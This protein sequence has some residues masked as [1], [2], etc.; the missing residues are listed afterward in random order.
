[1]IISTRYG[2]PV[3][4]GRT[5][6]G[7]VPSLK[8]ILGGCQ[9]SGIF[10]EFRF[11]A[12]IFRLRTVATIGMCDFG[13][14]I[15]PI[16]VYA[17]TC[18]PTRLIVRRPLGPTAVSECSS[19]RDRN[20]NFSGNRVRDYTIGLTKSFTMPGV[21]TTTSVSWEVLLTNTQRLRV[22][23]DGVLVRAL[24]W[25]LIRISRASPEWEL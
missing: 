12:R 7:T 20:R 25:T 18:G 22:T 6:L 2:N 14:P 21:K 15:L 9:V 5:F 19:R 8:A 11:P 10:A 16:P 23:P 17:D 13:E 1:M 3:G 4:L 24:V